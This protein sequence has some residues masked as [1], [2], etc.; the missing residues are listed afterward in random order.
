MRPRFLILLLVAVAIILAIAFWLRP[1]KS[2]IAPKQEAVQT[3]NT[4]AAPASTPI[5]RISNASSVVAWSTVPTNPTPADISNY[6]LAAGQRFVESRNKP[7]VFYG[8]VIDQDSNALSGVDIKVSIEKLTAVISTEGFVGSKYTPLEYTSDSDGRFEI[9]GITGDGGGVQIYKDGY[10]AESE[11][12]GFGGGASGSYANPVIFKM[13]NTNIHEQLITGNKTFDIVP[14]GRPYFINL[15]DDTINESGQGDLKVWINYT[16]QVVPNQLYDWSAGVVVVNGGLQATSDDAMWM[17]P[18]DGYVP[19]FQKSEQ[20]R[21]GERGQIGDRSFYLQLQNGNE[22]GRMAIDLLAPFNNQ[23]PGL[24]RLSY[25]INP[26]GSR[27][28]R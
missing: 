7:I 3:A 23:T 19:S 22:Y 10:E 28:L 13:W 14:D 16:N 1:V 4:S 2:T 6:Y 26:S 27:I 15:T 20:I 24:I 17:A 12:N 9:N 5:Q 8:R 21:G 25:A 18:A 11:K